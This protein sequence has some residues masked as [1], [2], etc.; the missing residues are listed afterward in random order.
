MNR[1]RILFT[2][3]DGTLLSDDGKISEQNRKAIEMTLAKRGYVAAS[4]GRPLESG[5]AVAKELGLTEKGCYLIAFNGSVLYDC[6]EQKIVYEKTIPAADVKKLFKKAEEAGIYIQTYDK[7][8]I[9]AKEHTKELDY[10]AKRTG[11]DYKILPDL[12]EMLWEDPYKAL[13]IHLESR[14]KLEDFQKENNA[15][16]KEKLNSFFSCSEYLE[17]CPVGV[18]KGSAILRLCDILHIPA[19]QAVAVGDEWNDISMIKAAGTGAAVKNAVPAA[20]EAADY[21]TENDNNHDAVAEVIE[22]FM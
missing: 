19:A 3:L 7:T 9:L 18:D 14:K 6:F 22:K 1:G 12:A 16:T 4:T 11:M 21:V 13:L 5:R 8:D 17:Y 20:K 10:Y 15:W 2:D